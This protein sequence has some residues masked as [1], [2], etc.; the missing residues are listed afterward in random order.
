MDDKQVESNN[1]DILSR[2][3]SESSSA[4]ESSSSEYVL[5]AEKNE[6]PVSP[7]LGCIVSEKDLK[8]ALDNGVTTPNNVIGKSIFY[9]CPSSPIDDKEPSLPKSDTDE[10]KCIKKL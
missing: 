6:S 8:D 2:K 5:V 1:K 9:D 4:S 10:G 3:S 7:V